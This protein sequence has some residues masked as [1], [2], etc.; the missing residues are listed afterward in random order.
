MHWSHISP[1]L[2]EKKCL[3]ALTSRITKLLSKWT[4]VLQYFFHLLRC[5][6]QPFTVAIHVAGYINCSTITR[7]AVLFP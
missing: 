3:G 6:P 2:G 1:I 7:V 4:P 5:T